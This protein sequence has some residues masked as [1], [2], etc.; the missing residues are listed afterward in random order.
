[1][2]ILFLTQGC[3]QV[4]YSRP[5]EVDRVDMV[6]YA[7]TLVPRYTTQQAH[8]PQTVV[9]EANQSISVRSNLVYNCRR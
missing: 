5:T 9:Y 3:H 1:M 2:R 6:K 7:Q 4:C 8:R